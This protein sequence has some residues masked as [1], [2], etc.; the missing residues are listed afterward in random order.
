[1]EVD[2]ASIPVFDETRR[3]CDAL[4]LDPLGVIASGALL[5][6]VAE[7]DAAS[8]SAALTEAGI[9]TAP[10]ARAVP[11]ERGCVLCTPEGTLPLPRY[12]Q[13]EIARLF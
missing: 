2:A 3:L 6:A 12:D 11:S 5:V 1:L 13:D 4:E 10:I 8:V 9:T 7:E